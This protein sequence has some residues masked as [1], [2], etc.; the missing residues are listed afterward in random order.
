MLSAAPLTRHL[1]VLCEDTSTL[2][3][4]LLRRVGV[5]DAGEFEPCTPH[6]G[7]IINVVVNQTAPFVASLPVAHDPAALATVHTPTRRV[8]SL[9]DSAELRESASVVELRIHFSAAMQTAL[10][11]AGGSRAWHW[12]GF[13]ADARVAYALVLAT[14]GLPL[15]ASAETVVATAPAIRWPGFAASPTAWGAAGRVLADLGSLRSVLLSPDCAGGVARRAL[16]PQ[17]ASPTAHTPA[18]RR[19]S[20]GSCFRRGRPRVI[21]RGR[22][23]CCRP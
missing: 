22:W 5:A 19:L 18:G 14:H 9:E 23:D 13:G 12:Q 8:W 21:S 1:A 15:T 2:V 16:P 17:T 11:Q 20:R 3:H 10:P 7:L 4:D 6:S